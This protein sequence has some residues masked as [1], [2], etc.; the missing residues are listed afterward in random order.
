MRRKDFLRLGTNVFVKSCIDVEDV[1]TRLM[2][3]EHTQSPPRILQHRSFRS[4]ILLL[5][6]MLSCHVMSWNNLLLS[7]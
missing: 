3:R 4:K 7:I 5:P 1:A 2:P 6:P